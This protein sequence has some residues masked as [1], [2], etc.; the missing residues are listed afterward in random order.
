MSAFETLTA[1]LTLPY[2]QGAEFAAVP[3][4][5]DAAG[6]TAVLPYDFN[7]YRARWGQDPA[8]PF[9]VI[10]PNIDVTGDDVVLT[11]G[12]TLGGAQTATVTIPSGTRAGTG[13]AIPVPVNASLRLTTVKATPS[14]G[15]PGRQ[16]W[17]VV[18]LLGNIAK[19]T[20][21]LGAEKDNIARVRQDVGGNRFVKS[22]FGAGLDALGQDMRV[23][24]FP[25][26]P[27]STDSDT[28]ALW[29]LDEVPAGGPVTTVTD[30]AT[31]AHPGTVAGAAPG[32]PGKY[33]TAF[34][35][36][37][38]A[39]AI[40]VAT[41]TDFNIAANGEMTVEAFV[42]ADA[43]PDVN[44]CAIVA[45]RASETAAGSATPGWSLCVINARGFTGNV[46]FAL[47][48]GTHEVRLF[49]DLSITDGRF[50]HV[51]GIVDR[52]RLRARLVIDGVQ[53]ATAPI[54]TLGAVAP[55]VGVTLGATGGGNN[56]SGAIDEVRLSRVARKTFHPA[57][58]EDD[59]A[60]RSRLLIFRRWVLPSPANL[61]SMVNQAAPFPNDPAPYISIE[62]NG[63]TQVAQRAVRII[64]AS[65]PAGLAIAYDGST[66]RDETI[67]G[68]PNDDAGF[69]PAL[70]L[71]TYS[72]ALVTSA[73]DPGQAK[74]QAGTG[75]VL[76]FLVAELTA[77]A[78]PGSLIIDHSFDQAG[79]TSLHSVGRALR[80]RHSTLS[81]AALG[82]V[83][84]RAGFMFV[85]N[86]GP[87]VAV[88]VPAGERLAIRSA[89][90]AADRVDVG[91]AFDLTIDPPVPLAGTFTW[92]I[93]APGP[94]TAHFV[95]H[96]ADPATLKTPIAS[97]PRVR[98]VTDTPGDIAVR[99]E[100]ERNGRKRS[101]TLPL[102]VDPTTVADG[103][104]IDALG[105]LN[106]DLT[107]IA[108]QP[109]AGFDPAFLITHAAVAAVNFDPNATKMQVSTRDALDALVALLAARGTAGTLNVTQAF[110]PAG[111]GVESVGRR[112]ILGHSTLDPGVLAA[113]ASRFFDY[114]SR[115]GTAVTA[116]V[117]PGSWIA[118]GTGAA[119]APLPAF[120]TQ[121]T[122][123]PLSVVP[124]GGLPA[125]TFNWSAR[126]FGPSAGRFD[127]SLQPT[128][129]FTPT[130][131][132]P[133]VL[134]LTY[135]KTDT[136]HA[137][138]YTFEIR[139]KPALDVPATVIPKAQYDII[140]NVLDAFHPIGIEVITDNIRTHVREIEQDPTKA[141]PAYSFPNFRL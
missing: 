136:T 68:T 135:V 137:A 124:T 73:G 80:L 61:I 47:C 52:T 54:D 140:M 51:A 6:T 123:L 18:S 75:R 53:R 127:F 87:N 14:V 7:D 113:L 13:F 63:P 70:D 22:G 23:P 139:L 114:V 104:A 31:P 5:A 78:T 40:S 91:S 97:R 118:I 21:L 28:I 45:R 101:G 84:H 120:I 109:D 132:G 115:A 122:V 83:A 131:N 110:V 141:F 43:P 48:D 66:P 117:R 71:I 86:L 24:R 10:S 25:P 121:G 81:T 93:I 55:P 111:P 32:A 59:D 119:G 88:A 72:N 26:R 3:L 108:G 30:Q 29:H 107:S 99:I 116:I 19:L 35:F 90:L 95:G 15:I 133:L 138:P 92:T 33:G 125:G 60:Y 20:W 76:D 65:L 49:A 129:N 77:A 102:R 57:L 46:L 69:D 44:P 27:Y 126:T 64:P 38:S 79:P 103:Q 62:T 85:Q 74:M 42:N 105:N 67:A 36:V 1:R 98:L 41:S 100:Y 11:I 9:Y 12:Y 134:V 56:L 89:P 50:H 34:A 130:A 37:G 94:A 39:S 16:A 96:S 128:A 82:V 58:G 2:R 106:P 8:T 17:S 4:G 112:L